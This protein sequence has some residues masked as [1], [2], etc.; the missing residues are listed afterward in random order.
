MLATSVVDV[1]VLG[2]IM[3]QFVHHIRNAKSFPHN[4][5][6]ARRR[7]DRTKRFL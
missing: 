3:F 5:H 1:G 2:G 6:R 4:G 7:D